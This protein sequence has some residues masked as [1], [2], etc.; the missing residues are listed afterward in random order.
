M[1]A[2]LL[3]LFAHL[4]VWG[5][6]EV[7]KKTGLWQKLQHMVHPHK[8]LTQPRLAQVANPTIFVDVSQPAT[9]APKNAKY[10]SDKNSRAANPDTTIESH[11]PK[12]TGKQEEVPK[13]EN[14]PKPAKAK[15][16]PPEKPPEKPPEPAKNPTESKETKP[17]VAKN[18]NVLNPGI[19]H[20]GKPDQTAKPKPHEEPK[21]PEK[22]RPRT[23]REALQSKQI[24]GM[25]MRQQGG[26]HRHALKSSLDAIATPFGA[27]DR[28][29][30]EA[31]QQR[32][33][34]L[35][36]SQQYAQ[37]RTGK[38]TIQ[39]HLNPD[40]SVTE[41]KITTNSVGDVLGYICLEA[42][43]QSAP[44]GKWPDD[45]RRMVGA[46]FREITFTFYYY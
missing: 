3:S 30:I 42:I 14:T 5:A 39:F 28:A 10:Y 45:M 46:N 36:D 11:Q 31:I 9:E 33:Y 40:G 22:K 26:V 41:S 24:A 23:L 8:H 27:Y 7:G 32:W 16:T 4:G 2:L 29:I 12:L 43:V 6:Y 37:D 38:V 17:E 35:L 1:I 34:D 21:P 19:L 25:E 44:F 18:F 13:T 20:P 15:P